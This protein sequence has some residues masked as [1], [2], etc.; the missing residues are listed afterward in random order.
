VFLKLP[1]QSCKITDYVSDLIIMTIDEQLAHL[2][3]GTVDLIREEDLKKNSSARRRRGSRYA[4][5]LGL[6]PT[7]PGH[8]TSDT[9]LYSKAACVPDLG[10]TVIF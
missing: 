5:K 10:H 9:R 1:E 6:D 2:R 8:S 7:A 4:V 3:K